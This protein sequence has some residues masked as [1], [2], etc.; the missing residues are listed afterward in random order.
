MRC[1]LRL[2]DLVLVMYRYVVNATRVDVE[3]VT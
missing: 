1:G 2:R 3:T